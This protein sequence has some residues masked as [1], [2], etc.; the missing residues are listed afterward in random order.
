MF[1]EFEELEEQEFG[2]RKSEERGGRSE[3]EG[4]RSKPAE[5]SKLTI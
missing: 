1:E 5:V 2:A 3:E 4:A